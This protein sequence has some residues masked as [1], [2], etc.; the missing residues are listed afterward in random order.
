MR[1]TY[2]SLPDP[3]RY[4]RLLVLQPGTSGDVL[5]GSLRAFCIKSLPA[6]EAISYCWGD[7]AMADCRQRVILDGRDLPITRNAAGTLLHSRSRKEPISL[8]LDQV[9]IN[10]E[11]VNER[12]QQ[13]KLMNYI[14]GKATKVV[15]HLGEVFRYADIVYDFMHAAE[16][17]GAGCK[18]WFKG[19]RRKP[20]SNTSPLR[21][22][23][24]PG[25]KMCPCTI[26]MLQIHE[27]H[28]NEFRH[29]LIELLSLPWFKRIWVVQE[30][31]LARDLV[32]RLGDLSVG[33][34][35]LY[36]VV[37]DILYHNYQQFGPLPISMTDGLK[38]VCAIEL[39]ARECRRPL[40]WKEM[41]LELA[42]AS[43][44]GHAFHNG[45]LLH[46]AKRILTRRRYIP[47]LPVLR[48]FRHLASTKKADKLIGIL[49]LTSPDVARWGYLSRLPHM[50]G[51]V[52]SC[53]YFAIMHIQETGT[54]DVLS[55]ACHQAWAHEPLP[56]W[57]PDWSQSTAPCDTK[58]CLDTYGVPPHCAGTKYRAKIGYFD[59]SHSCG[60]VL[61]GFQVDEVDGVVNDTFDVENFAN[62]SHATWAAWTI[63]ALQQ[64]RASPYGSFLNQWDAYWRTLIYNSSGREGFASKSLGKT[65]QP[66]FSGV[67]DTKS[68]SAQ[69]KMK[70]RFV[71]KQ[72]KLIRTK[73]G[74][75]G[76]ACCSVRT[77][78]KI[79]ICYGGR[80]PM[81]LR[82]NPDMVITGSM[83]QHDGSWRSDC[84]PRSFVGH[85]LIGGDTYVHGLCNGEGFKIAVKENIP[86]ILVCLQ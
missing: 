64:Q 30:A 27:S 82:Q 15:I 1:F 79:F 78:D 69:D 12:S 13:V 54:L 20:I 50:H 42:S 58:Y 68:K 66:F 83:S 62:P 63:F 76:N 55:A 77:G 37:T 60:L 84:L 86:T 24:R 8:W 41:F 45:R 71:W 25:K 14:Y 33:W 35:G 26:A 6:Y 29:G 32:V 17:E 59:F 39:L 18:I 23:T 5:K 10:Q 61:E 57:C 67:V 28:V 2:T 51:I 11:D 40:S 7:F 31:S 34:K 70:S 80:F 19:E 21:S 72:R 43:K 81:I 44:A 75:L 46:H 85:K 49:G 38:T 9:C 3:N 16:H 56:L 48:E 65:I 74:Y 53:W 22:V 36:S 4:M 47:V 73:R 52:G